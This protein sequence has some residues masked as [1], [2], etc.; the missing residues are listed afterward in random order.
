MYLLLKKKK[1]LLKDRLLVILKQQIGIQ[2]KM[3]TSRLIMLRL[4]V[5]GGS[6]G[7]AQKVMTMHLSLNQLR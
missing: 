6:G 3:V 5:E 4:E 1:F 2:Q 7:N